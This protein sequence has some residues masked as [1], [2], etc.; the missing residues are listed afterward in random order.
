MSSAAGGV[1]VPHGTAVP[2]SCTTVV[3]LSRRS[4]TPALQS[5]LRSLRRKTTSTDMRPPE[6][7]TLDTEADTGIVSAV[8]D[9]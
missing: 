8:P 7:V 6:R 2:V 5:T 4:R 3:W 9:A 1:D